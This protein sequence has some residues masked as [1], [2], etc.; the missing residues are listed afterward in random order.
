MQTLVV[1]CGVTLI[2]HFKGW[3]HHDAIRYEIDALH[4]PRGL[5]QLAYLLFSR[6]VREILDNKTSDPIACDVMRVGK[7]LRNLKCHKTHRLGAYRG[8]SA[9]PGNPTGARAALGR[10]PARISWEGGCLCLG[11]GCPHDQVA[12]ERLP[13]WQARVLAFLTYACT[14]RR[15]GMTD[16]AQ[17]PTAMATTGTRHRV[18]SLERDYVR[19]GEP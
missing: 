18:R 9:I 13:L 17:P 11:M 14:P 12:G 10:R 8:D 16:K 1:S 6:C 15:Q 4:F 3:L 19:S 5:K 2:V 7:I